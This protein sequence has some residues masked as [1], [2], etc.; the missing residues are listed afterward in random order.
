[1]NP[2]KAFELNPF[3]SKFRI[4]GRDK[5]LK[6][7]IYRIVAGDMLFIEGRQGSGKTTLLKYAIDNFRGKGKVVYINAAKLNKRLDIQ[8][9]I[10]KKAKGMVLLLDNVNY[11]SKKNNEKIKF[12]YDENRIQS[13]I[14]TAPSYAASSLSEAINM[15]IGRNIIKLSMLSEK[16][17]LEIVKERTKDFFSEEIVRGVCEDSDTIRDVLEKCRQLYDYSKKKNIVL[18]TSDIYKLKIEDALKEEENASICSDCS[19]DLVSVREYWRCPKC[20][21]FCKSCGVL[22]DKRDLECPEC[23]RGIKGEEQ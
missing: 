6:E 20:D 10:P 15:R 14:F 2:D 1:M 22:L 17:A 13:V 21:L 18:K 11:L 8:S 7:I 12:Y 5:A 9:A 19:A 16:D 4:V 23:G 3:K